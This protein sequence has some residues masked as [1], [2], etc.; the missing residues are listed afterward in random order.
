[1]S[2]EYMTASEGGPNP[3][4]YSVLE[5]PS[6]DSSASPSRPGTSGD[7]HPT[8]GKSRVRFNSTS[9]ANDVTNKRSSF[10]IRDGSISPTT[11][12]FPKQTKSSPSGSRK[13]SVTPLM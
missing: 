2:S 5:T 6:G 12:S 4:G 7:N 13:N 11:V 8:K 3:Q 10:H 1:M 9:E